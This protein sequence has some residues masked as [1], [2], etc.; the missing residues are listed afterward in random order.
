MVGQWGGE[1]RNGKLHFICGFFNFF[2]GD[3]AIQMMN[4]FEGGFD[5][6]ICFAPNVNAWG[7]I[8]IFKSRPRTRFLKM[9]FSPR[10]N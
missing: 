1:V 4:E 3:F 2:V 7:L 9:V 5:I 8:F 6:R 10:N